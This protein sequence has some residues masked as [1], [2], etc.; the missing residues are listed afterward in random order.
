MRVDLSLRCVLLG[1]LYDQA[2]LSSTLKRQST[3]ESPTVPHSAPHRARL[4]RADDS[5]DQ[6]ESSDDSDDDDAGMDTV[7]QKLNHLYEKLK[8][9]M[10]AFMSALAEGIV[11]L[12]EVRCF[13]G[14]GVGDG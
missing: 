3:L 13:R 9:G 8:E 14:E 12:L 4:C 2:P 10:N 1:A 5:K 6:E 7:A 11:D